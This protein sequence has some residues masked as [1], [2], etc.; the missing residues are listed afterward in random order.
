MFKV[1]LYQITVTVLTGERPK[2]SIVTQLN[3]RVDKIVIAGGGMD[4]DFFL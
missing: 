1:I 4:Q 2:I 3:Y